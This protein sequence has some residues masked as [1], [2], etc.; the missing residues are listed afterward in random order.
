MCLIDPSGG[1]GRWPETWRCSGDLAGNRRTRWGDVRRERDELRAV[2]RVADRVDWPLPLR[3][4]R[5]GDAGRADRGRRLRVALLPAVGAARAALRLPRARPVEPERGLRCNPNK[6]LL[7]PLRQGHG[8]RIDWDQ[9]L[10]SPTTS[11]TGLAQRRRLRAAHDPRRRHQP[12]F[13][14]EGDRRL[15]PYNEVGDPRGAHVKGLTERASPGAAPPTPASPT[16][17]SSSTYDQTALGQQV[18]EFK[19]WSGDARRGIEVILDVVYNH[20]AEGNH[21]GPTLSFKGI[22]NAATTAWSTDDQRYYMDYTGT[23]NSLNVRT[24]TPAADH[25]LLR[26]WVTGCTSTASASTSPPRSPAVLRRRPPLG[27]LRARAAGPGGQPGEADRRAVGHRARRLPG[28]Q[29][30]AAVDR[31]ERQIP[32]HRPR[33]LAQLRALA[34]RVRLPAGRVLRPLRALRPASGRLINFVTAHDGFTLRDLVSCDEKHNE[35]NGGTTT[36]ARA[37]TPVLEPRRRG[38]DRR[39]RDPGGRPRAAAQLPRHAAAG[40]RACRC[41]CTATSSAARS[42]A[43]TTPTP[44]LRDL[45]GALDEADRPLVEFTAAVARCAATTPRSAASGSS[46][47]ARSDVPDG[48]ADG[49]RATAQR[50]RCGCTSTDAPWRTAT[51]PAAPRRRHVPQQP[52]ASPASTAGRRPSWTTTSCSSSTPTARPWSPCPT[53]RYAESWRGR[54]R[55][56]RV[57][58]RRRRARRRRQTLTLVLRSLMVRCGDHRTREARS[59]TTRSPRPWRRPIGPG[60][61][62]AVRPGPDQHRLQVTPGSTFETG[63]RD[64]PTSTTSVSTGS[65]CRRSW[66]PGSRHGYDVVRFDHVDPPRRRARGLAAWSRGPAPGHGRA[67]RHRSQPRRHRDAG[68]EPVVVGRAAAGPRPEHAWFDVDWAAGDGRILVPVV[69]DGDGLAIRI[70]DGRGASGEVCYHD[71]RFPMAARHDHARGA[72]GRS[73]S[74]GGRRTPTQLPPLLR[75]QPGRRPAEDPSLRRTHAEIRLW[76]DGPGRRPAGRPPGRP[77]AVPGRYLDDLADLTAAP[78]C[79]SRRSS[80][81]EDLPERVGDGGHDRLRRARAGRPCPHRPGRRAP[82]RRAGDQAAGGPGPLGR[83]TSRGDGSSRSPTASSTPRS[84]GSCARSGGST[85]PV[86]APA[87]RTGGGRTPAGRPSRSTAPTCRGRDRARRGPRDRRT[88]VP[89]RSPTS[90]R[91]WRSCRTR[92]RPGRPGGSSRPAAW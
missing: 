63:R 10:F 13:D 79:W 3:R 9:A 92:G 27:V 20:T 69:G 11:A 71:H 91:S 29:L 17:R 14:W 2:Q 76:F 88:G 23:G 72:R 52:T 41:C 26:Y 64:C 56:R 38:A 48:S 73:W 54:D 68:R 42:R 50:H 45:L 53:A 22:D 80:G 33:L 18:Q 6:L 55:H 90:G 67:R 25:G 8:R 60:S 31:V 32:R 7:D 16:P 57:R 84:A 46:P 86:P 58:G 24:R 12:P 36:T 59:P 44:R 30:P 83:R 74:A 5:Q 19:S 65:T 75:G 78:A 61:E 87:P 47:A 39:P 81:P 85:T 1:C 4:G 51:G 15:H 70:E 40:A 37:T 21:L 49:E 28:R 43:T 34:R 77:H 62:G 89:S 35:A 66:Q 82:A